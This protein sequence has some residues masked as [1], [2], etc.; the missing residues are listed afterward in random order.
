MCDAYYYRQKSKPLLERYE[1]L[2]LVDPNV[3][4]QC[5]LVTD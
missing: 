5:H 3:D 1:V 4:G 2:I